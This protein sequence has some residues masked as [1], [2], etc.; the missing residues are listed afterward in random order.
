[1]LDIAM[2]KM[3]NKEPWAATQLQRQKGILGVA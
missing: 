2:P 3:T 1:M